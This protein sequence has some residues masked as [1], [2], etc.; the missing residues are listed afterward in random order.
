TMVASDSGIRLFN[1][2][3]PH[4]RGYGSNARVLA[5][6]V[7]EKNLIRLEDA[8]RKMTSLPAQKFNLTNRG[9]LQGGKYAD[10]VIFDAATVQDQSTFEHP[11]AYS[12]GF[13]YVLVNGQLTVD[14][15]KHIG[16]RKGVILHGAGYIAN[17]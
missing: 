4:P 5:Y 7:R 10:I 16:T 13:K 3:V 8:I 15:F 1:S 6:Y 2:G 9:L 14:N 17:K 11:N 12:T